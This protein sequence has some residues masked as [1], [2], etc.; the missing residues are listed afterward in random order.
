[1][2]SDYDKY[3]E[4]GITKQSNGISWHLSLV[5]RI[6]IRLEGALAVRCWMIVE[7]EDWNPLERKPP[8]GSGRVGRAND[9]TAYGG[10]HRVPVGQVYPTLAAS[11]LSFFLA[12]S[13]DFQS[14]FS[15]RLIVPSCLFQ[16]FLRK[17][18][19]P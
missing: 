12:L 19:F 6:S 5:I 18:Y 14:P 16:P 10:P 8:R 11:F 13:F 7:R 1:M 17:D 9:G 3:Y 4:H 2:F 15:C